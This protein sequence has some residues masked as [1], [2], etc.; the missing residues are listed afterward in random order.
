M[1]EFLEAIITKLKTVHARVYLEQAPEEIEDPITGAVTPPEFPYVTY[2]L[3][4]SSDTE[5]REDFILEIT[6]WDDDPDTEVLEQLTHDID[7]A[8]KNF[9]YVDPGMVFCASFYRLFRGMIP[10]PDPSIRRREL[11]IQVQVYFL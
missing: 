1:I 3:P 10:D 8:F 5:V 4:G 9:H 11:R 2:K 7:T 6:I